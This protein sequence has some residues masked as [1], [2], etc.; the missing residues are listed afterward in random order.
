[1]IDSTPVVVQAGISPVIVQFRY[2]FAPRAGPE[3]KTSVILI[4]GNP[5][6]RTLTA[7]DGI[8]LQVS[9]NAQGS[10][11]GKHEGREIG[12]ICDYTPPPPNPDAPSPDFIYLFTRGEGMSVHNGSNARSY[13]I[14]K[15]TDGP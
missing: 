14:L 15:Y 10:R 5:Y 11:N 9:L 1:D 6:T 4:L 7:P 13:P 8:N 3:I 2:L 12:L